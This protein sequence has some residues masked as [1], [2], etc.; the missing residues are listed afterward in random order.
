MKLEEIID[1]QETSGYYAMGHW[2]KGEFA[3]AC[4]L[5]FSLEPCD[6]NSVFPHEVV[7]GYRTLL[8]S[9]LD[10]YDQAFGF[11]HKKTESNS[12]PCTYFFY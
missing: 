8:D 2:D 1:N 4:I 12:K 3:E 5:E 7:L 9:P 10:G 6:L 11:C